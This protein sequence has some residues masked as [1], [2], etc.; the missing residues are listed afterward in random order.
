[1]TSLLCVIYIA[2]FSQIK[3]NFVLILLTIGLVLEVLG[4]LNLYRQIV[5]AGDFGLGDANDIRGFYGNKNITAAAIAFK[6]PFVL[7]LLDRVK[8]IFFKALIYVFICLSFFTLLVLSARAVYLS[9]LL[10]IAFLIFVFIIKSYF[11][12]KSFLSL[13][14]ITKHYILTLIIA[15]IIFLPLNRNEESVDIA[16]RVQTVVENRDD[17]SISQRLRFYNHAINQI[18]STP[19]I[20]CG[21]GNW[22]VVSIKYESKNMY[23]YVVPFF[24]HNDFLEIFAET[25]ILGLTP[26]IIFITL[27]FRLNFTNIKLW[28]HDKSDLKSVIL[29]MP[30]IVYFVDMN[31]NFPLARPSMQILLLLYVFILLNNSKNINADN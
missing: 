13:F 15:I 12:K 19:L 17:E 28:F 2:K 10:C 30:L 6:I 20:G 26:F 21:I 25:G 7:I 8:K 27:I 9:V 23:S 5:S 3:L 16:S 31:L 22:K 4:S 24:T 18:S 29:A 14:G 11:N 1:M